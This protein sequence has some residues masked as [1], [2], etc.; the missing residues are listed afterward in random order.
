[1]IEEAI[2][3]GTWI[4]Q[5][6]RPVVKLGEKPKLFDVYT[7]VDSIPGRSPVDDGLLAWGGLKVRPSPSA[8]PDSDHWSFRPSPSRSP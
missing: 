7:T 4:P 1:M 2:R 8:P 6:G 3:D 5:A